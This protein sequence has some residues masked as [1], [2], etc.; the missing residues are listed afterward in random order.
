MKIKKF[1]KET[2][3]KDT[4]IIVKVLDDEDN[5]VCLMNFDKKY[6]KSLGNRYLK[7][8]PYYRTENSKNLDEG[9]HFVIL[10]IQEKMRLAKHY[11]P[12]K[13]LTSNSKKGK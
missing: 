8:A 7:K 4:Q 10:D 1:K 13:T 3:I 11:Y 12:E 6:I 9:F 2:E 5:V